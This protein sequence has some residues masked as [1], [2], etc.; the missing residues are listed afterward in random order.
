MKGD[1]SNSS[2]G[3]DMDVDT[4]ESENVKP[5]RTQRKASTGTLCY[6]RDPPAS[7][8]SRAGIKKSLKEVPE[9]EAEI[10]FSDEEDVSVCFLPIS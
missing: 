9:S 3:E 1:V 5:V 2:S 6:L 4:S 7:L 8:A 10:E